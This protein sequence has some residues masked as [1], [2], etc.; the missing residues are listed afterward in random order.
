MP[1]NT[2]NKE[3][4]SFIK[5][6]Q[7]QIK[8][9]SKRKKILYFSFLA[10]TII[11]LGLCLWGAVT[12]SID[13]QTTYTSLI[14]LREAG[15]LESVYPQLAADGAWF[16]KGVEQFSWYL[17]STHEL[18]SVAYYFA[19]ICGIIATPLLI[20]YISSFMVIFFPKKDKV[21]KVD[22][23]ALKAD[24]KSLKADKKTLK[25]KTKPK[26]KGQ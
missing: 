21:L 25:T 17:V 20:Y 16:H 26:K 12:V 13:Q 3:S 24:K 14:S 15:L 23:K 2:V 4:K 9:M 5:N 11:C 6:V 8:L 10:I 19:V 22:K 1:K 18:G 7:S